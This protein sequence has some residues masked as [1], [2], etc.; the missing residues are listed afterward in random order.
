MS[1][2]R[3]ATNLTLLVTLS[4]SISAAAQN[5]DS[6]NSVSIEQARALLHQGHQKEAKAMTLEI[7][8]KEP[9]ADAYNLLGIIESEEQEYPNAL[10]TFQKALQLA[11]H[12]IQAHNN[13]GNVYLSEKKFDLAEREF[14]IVLRLDPHNQDANYN[15]GILLIAKGSP[16][17]AIQYFDRIRHRDLETNF[18]L[19]RAYLQTNRTAEALRL[20][21]Q[22]STEKK[23][24]VQLHF[25][26]GVLLASEKQFK[27]AQLELEKAEALQPGTFEILFNL[28][29]ASLRGGNNRNAEL[30]LSQALKL[31]PESPDTLYLLA[32]VYTKESRPL[33]ALDLLVRANKLAP[34]NPDILYSMAQ[35]SISQGFYE[36]ATPLIEKALQIAPG[37]PDLIELLGESYFKSDKTD[38]AISAFK[39]LIA[40]QPSVR[41]YSFLGLSNTYLGRFEE[42]TQDFNEGLKLDPHNSFCEFQLGYIARMQGDSSSAEAIFLRILRSHPDY[43]HALLELANIRTEQKKFSEA[44]ELLRRYV[45]VSSDPT[46]GYYKLA[47]VEKNLHETSAAEQDL[48]KFQALSSNASV[49]SHPYDSLFDYLDNR[50]ELAPRARVQQDLTD[51]TE[52]LRLHPNQPDVLYALAEAYLKSGNADEARNTIDQFDKTRPG[53]A[54]TL[55]QSGVLLARYKLY[56]DAIQ[57]F[58]AALHT[59]PHVDDV[60][61]DLADAYYRKG[62]FSD[63]LDAALGVTPEGRKDDAYLDLLGDIYAHLGDTVRAKGLYERAITRNPDNDQDY[64]SLALLEFRN[65]NISDAKQTLLK[66]QARIPGSGKIIWG[67]GLA[68]ALD[69][70]TP[71]AARQ[72][73][74]AVEILPEW[75]GAYSTLGVFYYQTGQIDKA[76]EVLDRFN[77]SNVRGGLD[78]HRIEETL[79]Q[80]QGVASTGNE[81]LSSAKRAQMLQLALFLADKTL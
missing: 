43:P 15:L 54:R 21:D 61:F 73:E 12:S 13:I 74:R 51:L 36:D 3:T 64:L 42:A 29:Q 66:G 75:A 33:D 28:G 2:S 72:L 38:K 50:S 53:D 30:V 18:S 39:Q 19:I 5:S 65:N 57:Q 22:L 16:S 77:N 23:D 69:G 26:L 48:A 6:Q 71:G 40:I 27:A 1:F 81:P 35:I 59:Q 24:D 47:M 49:T 58:L 62:L 44:A 70:D 55:T 52:Q 63:A 68:S 14:R 25:S 8:Q 60:S 37:R 80:T 4:A 10:D 45:R 46:T 41:A 9:A 79:A 76:K 20:A 17:E 34:D 67:L 32:Q 11:P 56:D 7:L 78:V 31:K